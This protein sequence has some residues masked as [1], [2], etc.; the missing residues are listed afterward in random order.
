[1]K[2]FVHP[3]WAMVLAILL[4]AC[5]AFEAAAPE[6]PEQAVAA[7]Y[8][9]ITAVANTTKARLAAGALTVE[10][11]AAVSAKLHQATAAADTATDLLRVGDAAGATGQLDAAAAI[12]TA[13]ERELGP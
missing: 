12:L 9:T 10:Q 3:G 6:T 1:M 5:T 2:R 13:L 8:S 4:S 7:T 11:A